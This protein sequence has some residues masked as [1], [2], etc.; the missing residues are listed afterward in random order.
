MRKLILL[1]ALLLIILVIGIGWWNNAL[2]P[3][4]PNSNTQKMFAV[5]KGVGIRELGN[6]LKKDSLIKDPVVFFLYIKQQGLDKKIEAGQFRLSP[7]MSVPKIAEE[8]QH[9]A[10]DKWLTIPEGFRTEQIAE[11]LK[12]D[13]PNYQSSWETELKAHEGYLFPDTYLIPRDADISVIIDKLSSTFNAKI[14]SIGLQPTDPNLSTIITEASLIEREAN[15]D[16]EKPLIASVINNRIADGMPL[17]IDATVQY[18][19]GKRSGKWW[20][21][22]TIEDLQVNSSYNTYK[23]IGLPPTPICNPGLASINA[24]LHPASSDYL[25]YVHDPQGNIHF[26]KTDSEHQANI[27]KY[28][29]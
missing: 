25:Y 27:N 21:V 16:A 29:H 13:F 20:D 3:V 8:L 6:Q 19:I 23:I 10:L 17:Q 15:T 22:P 24:A 28:L 18:A 9:G 5:S 7:S 1:A 26:A 11:E 4:N 12:N 2:Q 14:E